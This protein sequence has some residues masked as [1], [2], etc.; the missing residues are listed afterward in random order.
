MAEPSPIQIIPL[1]GLPEIVPGDDLA[2]LIL[3][4][5]RLQDLAVQAGDI[6]V[7]AQ[8]IV[9]KAEGRLV[10][11]ADIVASERAGNFAEEHGKDPRLI[12]LVLRE[13]KRIL[14]MER[15]I[16]VAETAHGFICANAGID[17]SNAPEGMAILLPENPDASASHLQHHL[18]A[19]FGV[20]VGVIVSDTF[21]RPWREGL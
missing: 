5:A 9:S 14:R 11:L 7:V 21:G 3:R 1:P 8:K 6:L 10:R 18:S 20:P 15:G 12:E 17:A 2:A 19:G 13:S 16:I 4:A